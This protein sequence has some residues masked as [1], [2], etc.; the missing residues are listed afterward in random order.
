M[1]LYNSHQLEPLGQNARCGGFGCNL[2]KGSLVA[3]LTFERQGNLFVVREAS[4][5]ASFLQGAKCR[6]KPSYNDILECSSPNSPAVYRF[7]VP[8]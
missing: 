5:R 1:T 2:A 8:S 6:L 4:E 3:T 7:V